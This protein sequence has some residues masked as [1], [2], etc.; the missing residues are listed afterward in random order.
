MLPLIVSTYFLVKSK[1][2]KD[3]FNKELIVSLIFIFTVI[4]LIYCQLLTKNQILIYFLIPVSAAYSHSYVIKYFNKKYLV[5]FII[6]TFI[7]ATAKYHIRFNENR[8]FIELANADLTLSE[9]I[10]SLDQRLNGLKWITPYYPK[11]PLKEIKLLLETK[12]IL[13]SRDEEKIIITDYQFF[14]SL[15]NNRFASPNKWYDELS[16]PNKKN[17]YYD[18]YKRFFLEKIKMNKIKSIFFIEKSKSEMHFFQEFKKENDC[19][20]SN[21]INKLLLEYNIKDCRF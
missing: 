5:Y 17:I 11:Q 16:I 4:I 2:R 21:E 18:S 3:N 20:I 1:V 19:V 13:L 15:L 12:N 14:N 6:A 8:K 10:T 9:D 7:F